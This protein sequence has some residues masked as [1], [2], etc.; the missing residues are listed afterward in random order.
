MKP[1]TEIV[2][3]IC[4]WQTVNEPKNCN[5]YM[6]ILNKMFYMQR[7]QKNDKKRV[8]TDELMYV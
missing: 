3:F 7:E 1:H 8:G 2:L 4:T 5:I 6:Y